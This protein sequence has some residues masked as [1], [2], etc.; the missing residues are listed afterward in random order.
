MS[1]RKK[2]PGYNP[3]NA[4]REAITANMRCINNVEAMFRDESS[5]LSDRMDTEGKALEL[6]ESVELRDYLTIHYT[7]AKNGFV[8]L[9]SEFMQKL[10]AIRTPADVAACAWMERLDQNKWDEIR[11]DYPLIDLELTGA[12]ADAIYLGQS[13]TAATIELFSQYASRTNAMH[14]AMR[15]GLTIPEVIQFM[16]AVDTDASAP[17]AAP[18]EEVA[19]V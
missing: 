12:S 19:H 2:L 7:R 3:K 8:G 1:R 16:E 4:A 5:I 11:H 14:K 17:V 13:S 9:M 15:L 6:I 18:E 10:A